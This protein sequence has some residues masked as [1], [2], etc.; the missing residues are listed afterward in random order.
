MIEASISSAYFTIL[1]GKSRGYVRR[2]YG[3]SEHVVNRG[4]VV[5]KNE[6]CHVDDAFPFAC[7]RDGRYEGGEEGQPDD[8]KHEVGGVA[9]KE[10]KE[11]GGK[12]IRRISL[13]KFNGRH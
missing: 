7:E 4:V 2:T 10:E 13:N 6:P 11:D 9:A 5:V 3:G 8:R 12:G 1:E